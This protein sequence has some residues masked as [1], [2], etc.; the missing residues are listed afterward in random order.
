[1]RGWNG[2]DIK[3]TN[4]GTSTIATF[5]GSGLTLF[6]GG[7]VTGSSRTAA[8][9]VG[10]SSDHDTELTRNSNQ[11][12]V[13]KSDGLWVMDPTKTSYGTGAV[14]RINLGESYQSIYASFGGGNLTV[15]SSNAVSFRSGGAERARVASTGISTGYPISTTS[16]ITMLPPGGQGWRI[17]PDSTSFRLLNDTAG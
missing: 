4:G 12:I 3:R 13:V 6:G 15:D 8:L 9:K 1:M 11:G 7:N 14:A 17:L 5:N 2:V 16:G 10:T